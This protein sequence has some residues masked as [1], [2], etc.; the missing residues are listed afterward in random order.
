MFVGAGS[1]RCYPLGDL[2]L[3]FGAHYSKMRFLIREKVTV[4]R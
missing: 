1:M 2:C 3:L 4:F